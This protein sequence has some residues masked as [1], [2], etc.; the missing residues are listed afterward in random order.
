MVQRLPARRTT[1][2]SF[3][4]VRN[5]SSSSYRSGAARSRSSAAASSAKR[6]KK[7]SSKL[8]FLSQIVMG[9]IVTVLCVAVVAYIVFQ[10]MVQEA[11]TLDTQTVLFVPKSVEAAP[12]QIWL[13]TIDADTTDSTIIAIDAVHEVD[14]PGG[15]GRYRLG[16]IY[17]LLTLE[18][19]DTQFIDASYSHALGV[20]ADEVVPLGSYEPN[21]AEFRRLVA[22]SVWNWMWKRDAESLIIVKTWLYLAKNPEP[23]QANSLAE[24][25]QKIAQLAAN[26]QVIQ[27][28]PVG[29]L[30][31]SE[32][33]GAAAAVSD[34]LEAS[35]ILTI[36]IGTFPHDVEKTT[37]YHDGRVECEP[38]L[39]R[40][41]KAML[42]KPT[43]T[44]DATTTTQY[45]SAI[46]IVLGKE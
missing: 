3:S 4:V 8:N 30:N 38:I 14:L 5:K 46:M 26:R 31:G 21:S 45:R 11:A 29:V 43:I 7:P 39:A 25:Q 33:A 44:L 13:L 18:K 41:S 2:S 17:P 36:R 34:L 12:S 42:N 19:K 28:C 15:Y 27:E 24:L 23:L 32:T 6:K 1:T 9:C 37:I 40:V 35:K 16:A 22:V 20:L 10:A